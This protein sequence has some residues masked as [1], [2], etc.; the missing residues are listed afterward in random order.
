VA[1]PEKPEAVAL[2]ATVRERNGEAPVPSGGWLV[3]GQDYT[4]DLV[5]RDSV[6]QVYRIGIDADSSQWA[7]DIQVQ[8]AGLE[9]FPAERRLHASDNAG[10]LSNG[11]Y[12]LRIALKGQNALTREFSFRP[13]W[14]MVRALR[15]EDVGDLRFV[16]RTPY[17]DG[18]LFPGEPGRLIVQLKDRRGRDYSSE[19]P[20]IREML[21]SALAIHGD[22]VTVDLNQSSVALTPDWFTTQRR[23]YTVEAVL[24]SPAGTLNAARTYSVPPLAYQGPDPAEVQSLEVPLQGQNPDDTVDPGKA[25]LF[26]VKVTDKKGHV[27][28]TG[29]RT[30]GVFPLPW[31]RMTFET[32]HLRVNYEQGRLETEA[33]LVKMAGRHYALTVS[34]AGRKSLTVT[35]VLKPYVYA[36]YRDR[37]LAAPQLVLTGDEGLSGQPGRAGQKGEDATGP[38]E[39]TPGRPGQPGG[40]GAAGQIGPDVVVAATSARTYDSLVELIFIEVTVHGKHSYYLRKP[41]DP[42]LAIVSQGGQGGTGG[43]GGEGGGGGSGAGLLNGADGGPGGSGGPGG[44]GGDGGNVQLFLG[45]ADLQKYFTLQSLPGTDGPGGQSGNGGPG[46]K[47]G[48]PD[49]LNGRQGPAG[50][51]G[52]SGQPGRPGQV[53]AYTGGPAAELNNN[54]PAPFKDH[55]FLAN[56]HISP[57]RH[58][59]SSGGRESGRK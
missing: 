55:L 51:T 25:L 44:A 36:W 59:L 15:P 18:A 16:V 41:S 20:A 34:Y 45:R 28:A 2:E 7:G 42:P 33:D 38:H 57:E 21:L 58:L 17:P 11:M 31:S 52:P 48:T 9:W 37:M 27:F 49:H 30:P 14:P 3:P 24:T 50:F 40:I 39:A 22:A 10:A 12:T 53:S 35:Y 6:E 56:F 46:G 26:Q 1:V 5:V 8:G 47:S 29:A 13:D 23:Q 4:L 19:T 54:P 43:A 32:E